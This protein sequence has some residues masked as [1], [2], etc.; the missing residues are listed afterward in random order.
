MKQ[1]T[2]ILIIALALAAAAAGQTPAGLPGQS[3]GSAPTG[4]PGNVPDVEVSL[5][6]QIPDPAEPGDTV[7]LSFR[8]E[9]RGY[10]SDGLEDFVVELLPEYPFRVSGSASKNAGSLDSR[11]TGASAL[12]VKYDVL[13]D[14]NA[15]EGTHGIRLRYSLGEGIWARAGPF[16]VTVRPVGAIITVASAESSS[17]LRAGVRENFNVELRNSGKSTLKNLRAG[18]DLEGLPFTPVG[19]SNEKA[20]R[21]LPP[22]ES[23]SLSFGLVP[24]S[25]AKSGAYKAPLLLEFADDSGREYSLSP[26]V[27][28]LVYDP[29]EFSLSL[30]DTDVYEPGSRGKVVLSVSNTGPSEIKFMELELLDTADYRVV[31]HDNPSY[32]GNIE[33]DDFE[34]AQFD[35][36]AGERE[37]GDVDL[38][39]RLTYKDSFNKEMTAEETVVLPLYSGAEA[40]ELGLNSG[41]GGRGLAGSY[42]TA[43]L[44]VIFAIFT[45]FMLVDCWK[46][47]IARYRKSL[48]I[49]II[50]T[51]IG[52]ALYYFIA[53]RG[54]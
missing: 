48:W 24:D 20:V 9:N 46:N 35:I 50:L 41:A 45:I 4:E 36:R 5:I 2:L 17:E 32:L 40:A 16:N 7:E 29:P 10:G 27:G 13:V 11:Q 6:N 47:P 19:S 51:G 44:I 43:V 12:T 1:L 14:E 3:S 23:V 8:V 18:L 52:A 39:V 21:N 25:D 54:R 37:P 15:D 53:R 30:K 42:A 22:G 26:D 49:V 31:S 34:T 28:L 33:A 38:E